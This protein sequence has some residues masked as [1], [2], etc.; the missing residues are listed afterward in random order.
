M[1]L[2]LVSSLFIL[3]TNAYLIYSFDSVAKRITCSMLE[4]T[5]FTSK[6]QGVYGNEIGNKSHLREKEKIFQPDN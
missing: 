6:S 2:I 5:E 4:Q 3:S 1:S